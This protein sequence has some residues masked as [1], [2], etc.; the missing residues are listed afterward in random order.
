MEKHGF[1]LTVESG[2][3]WYPFGMNQK[4]AKRLFNCPL[5]TG[6][7]RL[8]LLLEHVGAHAAEG[9]HVVLGQFLALV[10]VAAN[11]AYKLF[12]INILQNNYYYIFSD[13]KP[14]VVSI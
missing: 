8:L 10:D 6:R 9:A 2:Q 14:S 7:S 11:G 4:I 13:D 3:L 12:H 1:Q 5:S